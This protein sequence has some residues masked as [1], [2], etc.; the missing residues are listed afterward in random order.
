MYSNHAPVTIDVWHGK[1]LVGNTGWASTRQP[2]T[3]KRLFTFGKYCP[4]A[5][6]SRNHADKPSKLQTRSCF[7]DAHLQRISLVLILS[8][9]IEMGLGKSILFEGD[10]DQQDQKS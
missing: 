9:A 8:Y 2:S 4:Q 5:P 7:F 10:C 3:S 6:E 1:V